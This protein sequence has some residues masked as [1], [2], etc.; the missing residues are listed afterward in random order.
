VVQLG[1]HISNGTA[2][3]R[4]LNK[5]VFYCV[6]HYI[7]MCVCV[8]IYI[9]IYMYVCMYITRPVYCDCYIY[10]LR[11]D[12]VSFQSN[13]FVC[14]SVLNSSSLYSVNTSKKSFYVTLN[15]TFSRFNT[16]FNYFIIVKISFL[17]SEGLVYFQKYIS[18]FCH[19]GWAED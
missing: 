19:V 1:R 3:V 5:K 15:V 9:Y 13:V 10:Y 11:Q 14:K 2:V 6:V 18:Y 17:F 8:C 16:F 4:T 7:C 12:W